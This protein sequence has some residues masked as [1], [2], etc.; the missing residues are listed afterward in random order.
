MSRL[1]LDAI[2]I[3]GRHRK[4]MG[5]LE[6]LAASIREVGLLHPP[7]VTP[8]N[9]L[10]AGHR[11]IEA[12][13]LLGWTEIPVTVVADLNDAHTLLTAE[14]DENTCRE[15]MKPSEKVALG[16]E[17]AAME[18]PAA[19][20]RQVELGRS[21]GT[22]SEKFTQGSTRGRVRDI[23]T[24]AVGKAALTKKLAKFPGGPHGIQAHAK[25]LKDI[26]GRSLGRCMSEVVIGTYNKGRRVGGFDPI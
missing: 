19:R 21:H 14:R 17:L 16:E 22:P 2:K 13:R 12:A 5:D 4:D 8:D 24:D 9:T 23:V 1:P 18:R 25:A 15:D 11:R 10:V 6:S 3:T 20:E 26:T 7:A